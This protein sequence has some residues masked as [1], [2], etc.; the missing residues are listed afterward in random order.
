MHR[1]A[2]RWGRFAPVTN[3]IREANRT[4]AAALDR[5]AAAMRDRA[6]AIE[7]LDPAAAVNLRNRANDATSAARNIRAEL[8]EI[9]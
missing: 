4:A 1:H 5:Y 9:P 3:P 2:A 7:K 6:A 8:P